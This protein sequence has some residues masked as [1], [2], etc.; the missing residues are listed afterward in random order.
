MN[1]FNEFN[2]EARKYFNIIEKQQNILKNVNA[3]AN[4]VKSPMSEIKFSTMS[5]VI[6]TT[7]SLQ[8]QRQEVLNNLSKT[9]GMIADVLKQQQLHYSVFGITTGLNEYTSAMTHMKDKFNILSDIRQNFVELYPEYAI[10]EED[11]DDTE[12]ID[13]IIVSKLIN[14]SINWRRIKKIR[15]QNNYYC[16]TN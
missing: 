13:E 6:T 2:S 1:Y 8:Y 14:P 5:N 15:Q 7:N 10:D 11:I 9:V 3:A 12:A 4:I 16:F